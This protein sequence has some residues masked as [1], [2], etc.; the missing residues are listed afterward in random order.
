MNPPR[1]LFLLLGK[2][3]SLLQNDR[4]P[5]CMVITQH[6][7]Q[8]RLGREIRLVR[9]PRG[10][11][12]RFLDGVKGFSVRLLLD[13]VVF[14]EEG[15]FVFAVGT[16]DVVDPLGDDPESFGEFLFLLLELG[17]LDGDET[18]C[19]ESFQVLKEKKKHQRLRECLKQ[20]KKGEKH[21]RQQR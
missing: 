4:F 1:R 18:L 20:E 10:A 16:L 6:P 17:D 9:L 13:G 8:P 5:P 11:Q 2:L 21:I 3:L 14:G 19:V 15:A 12:T 7:A